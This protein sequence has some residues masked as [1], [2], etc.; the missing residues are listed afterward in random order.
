MSSTHDQICVAQSSPP[1]GGA[2][3]AAH[4]L[5][6]G[7]AAHPSPSQIGDAKESQSSDISEVG[8]KLGSQ[9]FTKECTSPPTPPST[10]TSSDDEDADFAVLAGLDEED[11]YLRR[12]E[13]ALLDETEQSEGSADSLI[14]LN[15]I[16]RSD[17][18]AVLRNVNLEYERRSRLLC[19][20]GRRKRSKWMRSEKH[21]LER[22]A[23]SLL[24]ETWGY[25]KRMAMCGVNGHFC[26]LPDWCPQCANMIRYRPAEFEYGSVYPKSPHWNAISTSYQRNPERAGLHFV[27]KKADR[28]AGKPTVVRRFNP[29]QGLHRA[30]NLTTDYDLADGLKNPIRDCF[31]STFIFISELIQAYRE[32]GVPAGAFASRELAWHFRPQHMTPHAHVLWNSAEEISFEQ[33]KEMLLLFDAVYSEQHCGRCFYPDLHIE[34]LDSQ[35]AINRW[36]YYMTKPMDFATGYIRQ[37]K[38]GTDLARLNHEIDQGLFQNGCVALSVRSPRRFGNLVCHA[39]GYIGAG[40]ITAWRK[41]QQEK[42][43]AARPKN[44]R[45]P[46]PTFERIIGV[47]TLRRN[48]DINRDSGNPS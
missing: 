34:R 7:C 16:N 28:K 48:E 14:A 44:Q 1:P 13:Y 17:V 27:V 22:V 29:Y 35:A 5:S 46:E 31:N 39:Q 45:R 10:N 8:T 30:D 36:L 32:S 23:I 9:C 38:G 26:Q 21:Y 2:D 42:R 6:T 37:A 40:S 11:A 41:A 47:E 18:G 3:A 15:L 43:E 19:F 4:G 20:L 25:G 12:A 33:A 24:S